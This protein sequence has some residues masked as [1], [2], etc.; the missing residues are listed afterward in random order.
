MRRAAPQKH[1][2]LGRHGE[3]DI[4]EPIIAYFFLSTQHQT[5][6]PAGICDS[7]NGRI[8]K[9]STKVDAALPRTVEFLHIL[10][11]ERY[12]F[13]DMFVLDVGVF[14]THSFFFLGNFYL[15]KI[16]IAITYPIL[17][18]SAARWPIILHLL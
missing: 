6:K 3:Q 5:G 2:I 1:L 8:D 17:T 13:N 12:V 16:N 10:P 18:S 14:H 7:H 15:V 9:Y 4:R 11:L